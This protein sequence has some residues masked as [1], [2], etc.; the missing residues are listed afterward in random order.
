MAN[1]GRLY[2][3]KPGGA[4]SSAEMNEELNQM[5][6]QLNHLW[7]SMETLYRTLQAKETRAGFSDSLNVSPGWTVSNKVTFTN[8]LKDIP[9]V[10]VTPMNADSAN[11]KYISYYVSGVTKSEFT[12]HVTNTGTQNSV[13]IAFNYI[14]AVPQ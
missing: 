14:A 13:A 7:T 12:L 6:T 5:I 9:I 8:K 10:V 3:F 2:T 4:I 1:I 11:H